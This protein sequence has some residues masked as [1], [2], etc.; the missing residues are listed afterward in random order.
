[1]TDLIPV[2]RALLS[3]SDKTGIVEFGKFLREYDVDLVSTGGTYRLLKNNGVELTSV[4]EVTG[5]PEILGGRVK[6]LQ[7]EI[8]GPILAKHDEKDL[9]ELKEH[10]GGNPFDMIVCN[11]YPFEETI[12][13][14]YSNIDELM[15]QIDIGGPNMVRAA[16]K[17][18]KYE[19]AATN[20]NQYEPIREDMKEN[21][22]CTTLETRK[23]LALEGFKLNAIYNTLIYNQLSKEFEPENKFPDVII[24]VLEK[25]REHRY[26][27]NWDQQSAFYRKRG[28]PSIADAKQ[29]HGK[30][31]S[32]NNDLDIDSAVEVTFEIKRFMERNNL[33][34]VG[35]AWFKHTTPNGMCWDRESGLVSTDNSYQCDKLSAYGGIL[36]TTFP[37]TK[38][39]ADY[40]NDNK[41]FLEV[42]TAP[43]FEEDSLEAFKEKK[44]RRL[45]D[46]TSI[47]GKDKELHNGLKAQ[48][49]LGEAILLQ[50]YDIN[51]LKEWNVVSKKKPTKEQKLA[52]EFTYLGPTKWA[53]SNSA[54]YGM[55]YDTGVKAVGI[56]A[57]QQSRVHVVKLAAD[58]AKEFGHD[59]EGSVMG[60]DSFFPFR[61]GLDAAV[62]AGAVGIIT[63]GGSVRDEEVIDAANERGVILVHCGK[64]VFRH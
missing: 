4:E 49:V 1:M 25:V 8:Q 58:K 61:D 20:P 13:K 7:Y 40:L 2:K 52:L 27:E 54:A 26:G 38:E 35:T 62:D 12:K 16:S 63:P 39:I 33:K 3:V 28:K 22:G 47:W 42:L 17:N 21:N 34:G 5:K 43:G 44:G 24:E 6:T 50:D 9:A 32:Y 48:G 19:V 60:T 18:Y 59:L 37:A 29:L 10:V 15:E 53:K 31:I 46:I 56:G 57:G 55:I 64:R 41:I 51:P 11:L 23:K 45:L 14:G 30:K 36:G